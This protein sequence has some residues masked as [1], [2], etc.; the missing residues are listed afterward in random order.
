MD[1]VGTF[2][3]FDL[4]SPEITRTAPPYG[5]KASPCALFELRSPG[6]KRRHREWSLRILDPHPTS[7]IPTFRQEPPPVS[8]MNFKCFSTLALAVM[9]MAFASEASAS[10]VSPDQVSTFADS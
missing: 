9:A 2:V 1:V 7:T 4:M 5:A 10:P 6:T 3:V 8:T